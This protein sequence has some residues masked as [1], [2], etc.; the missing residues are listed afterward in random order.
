MEIDKQ[1]Q[2][3]ALLFDDPYR[4]AVSKGFVVPGHPLHVASVFTVSRADV[5]EYLRTAALPGFDTLQSR[6]QDLTDGPKLFKKQDGY[7]I[8]W[9]ERGIFTPDQG[10]HGESAARSAWVEFLASSLGLAA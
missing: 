9:Q 7:Y 6:Y 4:W 5:I 10:P 3:E 2:I 8:G 1:S